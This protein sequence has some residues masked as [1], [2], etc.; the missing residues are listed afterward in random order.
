MPDVL[1][2]PE[3]RAMIFMSKMVHDYSLIGK[4]KT[5]QSRA[6]SKK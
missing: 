2:T 5:R 1:S 4:I 6:L 3:F